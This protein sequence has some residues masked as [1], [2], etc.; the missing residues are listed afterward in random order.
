VEGP[1]TT[2]FWKKETWP[3]GGQPSP[4]EVV[5]GEKE[6]LVILLGIRLLV[7][8]FCDIFSAI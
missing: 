4:T 2:W 8:H 3:E 1:F 6:A 5:K 7:K